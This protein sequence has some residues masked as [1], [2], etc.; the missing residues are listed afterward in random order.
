[1]NKR[2]TER[3]LSPE[4]NGQHGSEAKG[5][6][7]AVDRDRRRA[8]IRVLV[9][10][11]GKEQ[12]RA[13]RQDVLRVIKKH[14]GE[15]D[16]HSYCW[17][18]VLHLRFAPAE[19]SPSHLTRDLTLSFCTRPAHFPA[20][21][22]SARSQ[23]SQSDRRPPA[24]AGSASRLLTGKVCAGPRLNRSHFHIPDCVRP[25]LEFGRGPLSVSRRKGIVLCGCL[26]AL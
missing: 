15:M 6:G 21:Q 12:N 18:D 5:A 19:E 8:M 25:V 4:G 7:S 23:N 2:G 16:L 26:V 14:R 3:N 11:G 13:W 22:T 17:I 10:R 20:H 24:D 9:T 1:M